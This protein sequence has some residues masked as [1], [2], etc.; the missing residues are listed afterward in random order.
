MNRKQ[1]LSLALLGVLLIAFC[2]EFIATI[3][4]EWKAHLTA[5]L[6][7]MAASSFRSSCFTSTTICEHK[8]NHAARRG[9]CFLIRP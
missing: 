6:A 2:W 4:Y 3:C 9:F 8:K 7:F 1:A 5:I